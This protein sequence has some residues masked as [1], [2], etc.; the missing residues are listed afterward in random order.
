MPPSESKEQTASRIPPVPLGIGV[1]GGGMVGQLAHIATFQGLPG[2]RVVAL[3]ELRP[4]LAQQVASRFNI[5]AV[6]SD[7][8]AML[9]D[10]NVE[11]VVVVTRRPATGPVVRDSLS[12]GRHV[13]SEKPMAHTAAQG[14]ELVRCATQAN[15]TYA[16]GYMKRFDAGVEMGRALIARYLENGQLGRPTL[17]HGWCFA[18]DTGVAS[19]GFSMTDEPRPDGLELWPIAPDWMPACHRDS[20]AWFLNVNVHLLNLIRYLMGEMPTVT[21]SNVNQPG[22][23]SVHLA[24]GTCPGIIEFEEI[25]SSPWHEGVTI[26]FEHGSV[27]I[28]LPP[29]LMQ[30]RSAKVTVT[31]GMHVN[32]VDVPA[33]WAF[34]RQASAFVRSVRSNEEP[35]A[36]GADSVDDLRLAEAIWS[37]AL[38][39][40]DVRDGQ[41]H[42][43][44]ASLPPCFTPEPRDWTMRWDAAA[45]AST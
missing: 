10:Q 5:P 9:S 30:G 11:A 17:L 24:F 18:G 2:C 1:V 8:K 12:G 7:H 26:H 34:R 41:D 42:I 39:N 40:V 36:S 32:A 23:R 28:D 6:Y 15:R 44:Q 27:R 35:R 14:D 29:P 3:A 38:G 21:Q 13:L 31:S 4:R 22:G 37:V 43:A 25:D 20:F 33:D 16:V 45:P 19:D